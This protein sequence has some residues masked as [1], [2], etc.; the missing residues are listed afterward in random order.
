MNMA[1]ADEYF[2]ISWAEANVGL[3]LADGKVSPAVAITSPVNGSYLST[4]LINVSGMVDDVALYSI[5]NVTFTVNGISQVVPL[6]GGRF[7]Q[8]VQLQEGVNSVQVSAK[9]LCGNKGTASSQFIVDT[10]KPVISI[11]GVSN[12]RYYNSSVL[13]VVK[14]SEA[15]PGSSS[16]LLDGDSYSGTLVSAEGA[17]V[18][19]VQATD[20]AGNMA[21]ASVS[22]V[23]DHT[24]PMAE[25][26]GVQV[27][28]FL[29]KNVLING[30]MADAY[31]DS[32][33][34]RI[35]GAEVS[36]QLPFLWNT[37]SYTD[38][39][40]TIG[41][42]V[43]DKALNTGF[44]LVPVTVD[45]TPP[46]VK[47]IVP[48]NGSLSSSG[49]INFLW[50]GSDNYGLSFY[51]LI[52]DNAWVGNVTAM[53]R[54]MDGLSDG[55]HQA[56]VEAYDQANNTTMD[57]VSFIVDTIP[58]GISI[59][60]VEDGQS[61]SYNVT[62]D[63]NVTDANLNFTTMTLNGMTYDGEP[64]SDEGNYTLYVF[65]ED[66]ANNNAS[67]TINFTIQKTP[68]T[69]SVQEL[70]LN[71]TLRF[72]AYNLSGSVDDNASLTINGVQIEHDDHFNYST[73]VTEGVNNFMVIATSPAE[74]VATWNNV[75][76][77]DS[78]MLPDFYEIN[79]THTD[80]LKGDT[81]DNGVLDD[82][83]DPDHDG[84]TNIAE[85]VFGTIPGI[86]T[87]TATCF[88]TCSNWKNRL[89]RR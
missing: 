42:F 15:N 68:P 79:V 6:S 83:E 4:S 33:S 24:A 52:L 14:I 73:N 39:D 3:L 85:Y 66:L 55:S 75:R 67:K 51:R 8:Q 41:L 74:N 43:M 76:L 10:V 87:P 77:I 60:N 45:N 38:G 59:S 72:P 22:F 63:V 78:D 61:Y 56:M 35:D 49:L 25:L 82:Q 84:L 40:H 23:I 58:P 81:D 5:C 17:H 9:D 28:G 64:V 46:S 53:N 1:K 20:L 27:N 13:P 2:G 71:P 54:S 11:G 47:L 57:S 19:H 88:R 29:G 30:G 70:T 86:R 48:V 50:S 80:P 18:L 21:D 36:T 44:S 65:A 26:Y 62:P 16:I 37:S 12:G 31:P 69:L 89:L 34:L 7:T 32:M